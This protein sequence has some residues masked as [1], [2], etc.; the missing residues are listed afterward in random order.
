VSKVPCPC[1]VC[2]VVPRLSICFFD[3][4]QERQIIP[5]CSKILPIFRPRSHRLPGQWD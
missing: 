1:T 2:R 4:D 5:I 3:G